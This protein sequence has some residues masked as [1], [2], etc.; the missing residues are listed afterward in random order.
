LEA[1]VTVTDETFW[2]A[3]PFTQDEAIG[4]AQATGGTAP[5]TWKIIAQTLN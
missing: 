4:T 5:Y 1:A 2:N 3:E